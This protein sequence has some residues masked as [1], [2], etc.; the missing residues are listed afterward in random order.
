MVIHSNEEYPLFVDPTKKGD[1]F[2]TGKIYMFI[3][4]LIYFCIICINIY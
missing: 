3:K 1:H 4:C 2:P